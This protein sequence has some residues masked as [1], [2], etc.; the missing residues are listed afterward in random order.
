MQNISQMYVLNATTCCTSFNNQIFQ[1]EMAFYLGTLEI[2]FI[3]MGGMKKSRKNSVIVGILSFYE[4]PNEAPT[5]INVDLALVLPYLILSIFYLLARFD[6][7]YLYVYFKNLFGALSAF[8]SAVIFLLLCK[9]LVKRLD[10]SLDFLLGKN[11]RKKSGRLATL[12]SEA[13]GV[14]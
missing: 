4:P 5:C 8:T 13:N 7:L 10:F 11:S 9:A 2:N 3:G 6:A 1:Y 12:L 14:E